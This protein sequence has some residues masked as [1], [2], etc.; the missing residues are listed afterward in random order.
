[1]RWSQ[2]Q[3]LIYDV[4]VDYPRLQ[5]HCN[6]YDLSGTASVGRWWVTL[7]KEVIWDVPRDF[8]DERAK[9]TYNSFASEVT[10]IIRSYLD[11]SRAELLTR[12][13][14]DDRWSVVEIF[15]AADRRIGHQ[16][17]VEL[18]EGF[19]SPA[20]LRIVEERILGP[21]RD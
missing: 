15:R 3:K 5:I 7:G 17:L 11:T 12:E 10:H 18:S 19:R 6:S 21:G 16:R 9:G 4:W 2:L 14:P 20:A 8:P 1:M 13:F